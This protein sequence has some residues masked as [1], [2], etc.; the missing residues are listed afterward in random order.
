MNSSTELPDESPDDQLSPFERHLSDRSLGSGPRKRDELFYQCGYAAG[1]AE[2]KCQY[3][4]ATVR[5]RVFG[6]AASV[7][8]CVSLFAHFNLSETS[9][10]RHAGIERTESN[11]PSNSVNSYAS[12]TMDHLLARL[13]E[14]RRTDDQERSTLRATPLMPGIGEMNEPPVDDA[15]IVPFEREPTLQPRDFP[16]FLQGEV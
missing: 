1:V 6:I 14:N 15:P 2:A 7:L 12:Q 9:N 10:S 11:Q 3:G 16:R 13:T 8:A 5:W 4:R